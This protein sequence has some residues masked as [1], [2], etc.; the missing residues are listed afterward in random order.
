MRA[1]KFTKTFFCDIMVSIPK[2]NVEYSWKKV[3]PLSIGLRLL[4]YM[5]RKLSALVAIVLLVVLGAFIAYDMANIYVVVNDGMSQRAS[6]ILDEK[7]PSE[8][9]KYFTLKYLNSDPLF[10]SEKY[11]DYIIQDYDFKLVMK[12]L[13]VWPWQSHTRLLVEEYIPEDSWKFSITDELREVLMEEQNQDSE[14]GQEENGGESGQKEKPELKIAPPVW[15][16]GEKIIEMR[17]VD[18]QWK[19]DRIV[20]VRPLNKDESGATE[21]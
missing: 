7:D 21:G 8:L 20:F 17:K 11:R 14:Q 12:R 16:N 3:L 9:N 13:W 5:V 10:Y 6:I 4:S 18:G 2:A 15:Q 1:Y 19:I